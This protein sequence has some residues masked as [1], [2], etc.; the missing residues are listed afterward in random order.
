M[1]NLEIPKSKPIE[2]HNSMVNHP[3]HYNMGKYEVIDVIEDWNLN[4]CL[5]NVVKYIARAGHKDNRQQ[6][7]EKALFYLERELGGRRN[8]TVKNE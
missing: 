7:L 3:K 1:R 4:F 5:G 2:R 8:A 6:D